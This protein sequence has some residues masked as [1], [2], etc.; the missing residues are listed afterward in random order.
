MRRAI[1]IIPRMSIHPTALVS[2]GAELDSS[3][4]VGPYAI[5]EDQVRI[6]AGTVVMARAHLTGHTTIGRDNQ[7]HMGA[8][9][10]HE[11]QDLHFQAGTRSY[12]RIGD[13]NV[14]R[15][16]CTVHRGTQPESGTVI[17]DDCL[18]MGGAHVGHNC[19]L[20]NRVILC[21]CVLLAGHV[22]VGERAFLSGGAAVHQFIKLGGGVMISGNARISMDVPPFLMAAE[23]NE[24]YGI[25]VVGLKRSNLSPEANRDIKQ[26]FKLFYRSGLTTSA[27]LAQA[28]AGGG[29]HT[30][31][32]RA[33]LDFVRSSP[34]GICP[35]SRGRHSSRSLKPEL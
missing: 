33:F 34:N 32:A 26:L 1:A 14:F 27:A 2:P 13:R 5:I 28:A 31:E 25:N 12:L 17:G 8:V 21:N 29:F 35:R 11:P 6:A 23:R 24:I 16:Y 7:I 4:H 18:L 30:T 19:A 22:T 10:G 3:V 15:E 9:L 20:G